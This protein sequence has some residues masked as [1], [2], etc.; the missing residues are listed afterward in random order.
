MRSQEPIAPRERII[1]I[2]ERRKPRFGREG[3]VAM[4]PQLEGGDLNPLCLSSK[5][6]CDM[7]SSDPVLSRSG[8]CRSGTGSLDR[9]AGGSLT[10]EEVSER[11]KWEHRH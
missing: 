3:D 10:E 9:E 8:A 4:V 7:I 5:E 11:Q 6:T 2:S 1:H